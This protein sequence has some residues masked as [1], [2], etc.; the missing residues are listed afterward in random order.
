MALWPPSEEVCGLRGSPERSSEEEG[1]H[2]GLRWRN[3]VGGR[4]SPVRLSVD[5][6][7]LLA[8]SGG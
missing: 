3:L 6:G 8:T 1:S 5:K 2:F 4:T 7:G